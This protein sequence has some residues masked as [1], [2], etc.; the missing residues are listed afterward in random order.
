LKR[1]ELN[2]GRRVQ[3]YEGVSEC[4]VLCP[5]LNTRWRQ[6]WGSAIEQRSSRGPEWGTERR[7]DPPLRGCFASPSN[8]FGRDDKMILVSDGTTNWYGLNWLAVVKVGS[9]VRVRAGVKCGD[10]RVAGA[11]ARLF[12]SAPGFEVL[13]VDAFVAAVGSVEGDG[14]AG[15]DGGA[16]DD[17]PG[18]NAK[19]VE[20]EEVD[21][22]FVVGLDFIAVDGV[23]GVNLVE[24]VASQFVGGFDLD[25][26]TG[27]AAVDDG[28]VGVGIAIG[29]SDAQAEL[30]AAGVEG[31][32]AE[33]LGCGRG[34]WA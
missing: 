7:T 1:T 12:Q 28:V 3:N 8:R 16:G 27:V 10:A 22:G 31:H 5:V 6:G 29:R 33:E 9:I 26:P 18:V 15:A 23:A 30:C 17:V 24:S 2:T 32:F 14:E 25:A 4:A 34:A 13:G 19:Q 20:G 11:W 21:V